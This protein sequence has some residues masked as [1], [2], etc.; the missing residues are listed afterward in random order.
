MTLH[1]WLANLAAYSAQIAA[2]VVIGS[3]LPLLFRLRRPG[4]ML[5]YRQTLLAA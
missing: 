5:V 3:A 1:L 4:V 2:V